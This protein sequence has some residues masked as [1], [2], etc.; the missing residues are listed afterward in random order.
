MDVLLHVTLLAALAF[1][2]LTGQAASSVWVIV[3]RLIARKRVPTYPFG[4]LI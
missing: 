4:G 1:L 3:T 2:C